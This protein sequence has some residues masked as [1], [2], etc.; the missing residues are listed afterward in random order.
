MHA[1]DLN[2]LQSLTGCFL[3]AVARREHRGRAPSRLLEA[4]RATW[5]QF[6]GNLNLPHLVG[7]LAE[8]VAVRFALPADLRRVAGPEN[9]YRW[10]DVADPVVHRILAS[11]GEE[12]LVE[13]TASALARWSKDLGLPSRFAAASLHKVQSTRRVLELP[14]TGGHLA[15][16]ALES[17]PE[18]FLHTNFT[19]LT[20]DWRDRALA[21]LVAMELDAPHVEFIHQDPDLAFATDPARRND[22]DLVFGIKSGPWSEADLVPK[23][24]RATLVLV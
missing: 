17:S 21:G 6:R 15:A 24:P 18:A 4:G 14:G 12:S 10:S 9:P 16:R 5:T 1:F 2:A 20:S 3:G 7:L 22:F 11:L 13:P 23:F 8:D 19:V